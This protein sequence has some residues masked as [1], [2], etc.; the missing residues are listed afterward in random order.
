[1]LIERE[2]IGAVLEILP[3]QDAERFYR[4]DKARS[5]TTGGAGLGLT[6]VKQL[7][8]AHGGRVWAESTEDEGATFSFTL[9][10]EPSESA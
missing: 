5:R 4:G 9:P 2:A 3:R 10:L 1:M 7:V 6:I 8:E